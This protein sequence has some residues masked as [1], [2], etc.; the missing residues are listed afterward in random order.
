MNWKKERSKTPF[1]RAKERNKQVANS[2]TGNSSAHLTSQLLSKMEDGREFESLTKHQFSNLNLKTEIQASIKE[3]ENV[4]HRPAVCFMANTISVVGNNMIEDS[5]DLPFE[6]M[7][8]AIDKDVKEIDIILETPG[9]LST[10]V[11]KFVDKLRTR[12]DHIGFVILNKAM[13][14]GTMFAMSGDEIVMTSSS[15]IGPI[16]PQ[17]RRMNGTFL[18]A[19]SILYLIE[20]VKKRGNE[21]IAKQKPI[22]WTDQLLINGMDRMEAGNA[23]IMSSKS[24]DMVENYLDKYKFK[25]WTTHKNGDP[26]TSD[27]KRTRANEIA[28]LLCNHEKWKDHGYAIDRITAWEVCQL[29]ITHSE[30]IDGMDRAMKRMW[31]LMYYLFLNSQIQKVYVSSNYGIIRTV[32]TIT[33]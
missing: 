12:F 32:K 29:K 6:E 26:V 9:G 14:A 1:D 13:S 25:E 27:Q 30:S 4:R 7:I 5:D 20:E 18:P 33:K 19:Q 8:S 10:T 31:A 17:V 22:D 23:M 2:M 24:I 16:D 3:I 21:N 28:K 15:Q 11:A